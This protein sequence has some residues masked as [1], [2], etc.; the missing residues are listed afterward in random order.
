MAKRKRTYNT[1]AKRKR[2]YNTMAKRK[3]TN[4]DLQNTTYKLT[5]E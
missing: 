1:M 3:R 4:K 2:T 5:I